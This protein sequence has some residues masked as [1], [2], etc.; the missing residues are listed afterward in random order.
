MM[1]TRAQRGFTLVEAII[2]IV[3]TGIL[4]AIVGVF[5]TKPAQG[6]SDAVQRANLTDAA[7]TALRRL[8]RDIHLALP[9]SVRVSSDAANYYLEFI[10]TSGGGR[11]R[12]ISDGSTAAGNF[13]YFNS[14]KSTA[15]FDVLGVLPTGL[16]GGD[17][18]VVYNLGPG[19]APADAYS[20]GNL[21]KVNGIVGNTISLAVTD[22]TLFS[23]QSPPLP[24]PSARFQVIPKNVQAVTYVCPR[25]TSGNVTRYWGYGFS[26]NLN[27]A[28]SVTGT[29]SMLVNK[30]T[31]IIDY[32][33]AASNRNGLLYVQLTLM[34]NGETVSLFQQIHVDNSP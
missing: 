31:C 13:L 3:I 18:I 17:F 26:Q 16:N 2:V 34:N 1:I 28:K 22:Q 29:S 30:A 14:K 24:S 15:T 6:Y 10:M 33:S 7:D 9:N 5:I 32:T 23:N 25:Q 8:S 27:P 21:V 19:Y 4:A 12:D 20:M 11:Y